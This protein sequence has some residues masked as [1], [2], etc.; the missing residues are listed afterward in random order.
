[1]TN[2]FIDCYTNKYYTLI[3]EAM[4]MTTGLRNTQKPQNFHFTTSKFGSSEKGMTKSASENFKAS[5]YAKATSTTSKLR[6]QFHN[7]IHPKNTNA[8]ELLLNRNA[9]SRQTMR[10]GRANLGLMKVSSKGR[11]QTE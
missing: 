1:V 8:K 11:R 5:S 3:D 4:R 9:I 6:N 7:K 10:P 2:L